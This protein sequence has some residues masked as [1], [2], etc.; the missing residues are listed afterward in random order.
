MS[1]L[2][3]LQSTVEQ[4]ALKRIIKKVNLKLARSYNKCEGTLHSNHA[5][6][7]NTGIKLVDCLLQPIE[8]TLECSC[9]AILYFNKFGKRI[10]VF[11]E[12]GFYH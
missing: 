3:R 11:C 4:K 9:H 12:K 1:N 10:Y 7:L 2:S 8:I 6:K 5:I